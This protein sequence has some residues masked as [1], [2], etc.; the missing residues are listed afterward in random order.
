MDQP[1]KNPGGRDNSVY[2][3]P[4]K[5]EII[6]EV[7]PPPDSYAPRVLRNL[8]PVLQW[9]IYLGKRFLQVPPFLK[10]LF[11]IA[12]VPLCSSLSYI[13]DPLRM[14][15]FFRKDSFLNQWFVKLS[16]GWTFW[17]LLGKTMWPLMI[18]W[19][20]AVSRALPSGGYFLLSL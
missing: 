14:F 6:D 12:L 17:L 4:D 19:V 8:H 20:C 3:K 5:A 13:I 7:S 16:W 10:A 9:I 15:Y 1:S 2:Q 18:P 11:Y